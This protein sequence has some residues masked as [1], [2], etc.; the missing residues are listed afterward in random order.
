MARLRPNIGR[1][2]R[3]APR[4]TPPARAGYARIAAEIAVR[5]PDAAEPAVRAPLRSAENRV[6]G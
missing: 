4:P 2:R 1:A 5:S 6:L 3:A